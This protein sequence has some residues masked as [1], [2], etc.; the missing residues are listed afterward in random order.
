MSSN[1]YGH[2]YFRGAE[3]DKLLTIA[4]LQAHGVSQLVVYCRGKRNGYWPCHHSGELPLNCFRAEEVLAT[5]SDD[6]W[7]RADVRPDYSK[8]QVA[9]QGVGWIMPPGVMDK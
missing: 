5:S 8:Q 3:L 1:Q 7:R 2:N 9:S 4:S 6:G